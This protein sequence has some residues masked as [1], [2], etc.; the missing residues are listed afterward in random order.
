M[1]EVK[2]MLVGSLPTNCYIAINKET[3]G[4]LIIDPGFDL[5]KIDKYVV[6]NNLVPL[7]VLITHGHYDHITVA[8]DTAKHYGIKIYAGNNEKILLENEDYNL[9]KKFDRNVVRL[10]ADIFLNDGEL[11]EFVSNDIINFRVKTIFTPG[12]T[13]GGVCYLIEDEKVIF[14]GDTLFRET[15]GRTD[16]P[17]GDYN[18]LMNSVN[19][20]LMCL[21]DDIVVY[22]GHGFKTSI[23]NERENNPYV[24]RM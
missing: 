4:C 3:K 17:T 7:A 16:L 21:D 8:E 15:I 14:T 1:I 9:S 19:N 18:T 22:P 10:D 6:N 11:V 23:G 20:R 24:R 12:H 5:D 13:V 2:Q